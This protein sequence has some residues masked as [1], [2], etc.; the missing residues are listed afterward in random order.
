MATAKENG[1][2]AR[3]ERDLSVFGRA[4][5][6]CADHPL[7]F[8]T[9]LLAAQT[10]PALWSKDVWLP[11]E[12]RHA[13]VFL[14]MIE[15]GHWLALQLGDSFYA[16]K[17][18]VYFWFLGALWSV[19]RTTEPVLFMT[20]AALS[21]LGYLVA[22]VAAARVMG[23]PRQV[24]LIAGLLLLSNWFFIDRAHQP[25][26]D[27]MFA[28]FILLAHLG[29]FL[30]V[31]AAG[32]PHRGWALF[33]FGMA[34]LAVLV[35]GPLGIA[36]PVFAVVLHLARQ[37]RLS[38]LLSPG[39]GLGLALFLAV[40]AA[41]LAGVTWVRGEAFI[42]ALIFDQTLD[43]GLDV[44]FQSKPFWYYPPQIALGFLPWTFALILVPWRRVLQP[45]WWRGLFRA[46]PD[47]DPGRGYLWTILLSGVGLLSLIDYKN[48]FFL[49]PLFGVL[50]ILTADALVSAP[51]GR[52]RAVFLCVAGLTLAAAAVAPFAGNLTAWPEHVHGEIGFALG[53]LI[54]AV[55]IFLAAGRPPLMA[56]SATAVGT[57]LA[58]LPL[59][60]ITIP[61][62]NA[63]M[64]PREA[65]AVMRQ[66][67][68]EGHALAHYHQFNLGDLDYHTGRPIAHFEDFEPLND[69][70]QE[71][72]CTAVTILEP[73]VGIWATIPP[74]H[75]V[76]H[77]SMM[78]TNVNLV[79]RWSNGDCPAG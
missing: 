40:M 39:M 24:A 29:L 47:E 34:A 3:T 55:L 45:A 36:F 19:L 70:V 49:V 25:R 27:L 42:R 78:D 16:D 41:Y 43:R 57:T 67:A 9:V 33:G 32:Q 21:A 46:A 59:Y 74:G 48:A 65:G 26:M 76:V 73:F 2:G 31:R 37:R 62:L 23:F 17:P 51:R 50:A 66:L 8:L 69:F 14:Q 6:W 28:S 38:D 68:D 58:V 30:A 75:E 44:G 5:R 53:L 10:V 64:A 60:L 52:R 4:L 22:H 18:P 12:V 61:G 35:K 56:A 7:L 71:H 11:D 77:R 20:A 13:A 63:V 72:P 15:N 79:L 54:A 1:T